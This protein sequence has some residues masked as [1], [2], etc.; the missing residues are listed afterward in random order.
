MLKIMVILLAVPTAFTLQY[1]I[2]TV[3]WGLAVQSWPM[4]IIGFFVAL[5]LHAVIA[6]AST[7]D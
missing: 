4:L 3:G 6:A 5:V 1:L 7:K 2:M